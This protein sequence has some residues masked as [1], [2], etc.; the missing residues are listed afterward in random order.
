MLEQIRNK[1]RLF[2]ESHGTPKVCV[3]SKHNYLCLQSE[4][5]VSC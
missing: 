1:I 2:D 5:S 3:L 4:N